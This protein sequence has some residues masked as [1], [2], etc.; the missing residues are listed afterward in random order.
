[1]AR[2]AIAAADVRRPPRRPPG[3]GRVDLDVRIHVGSVRD[4]RGLLRAVS[5]G[6]IEA[7]ECLVVAM[8]PGERA[9]EPREIAP[10]RGSAGDRIRVLDIDLAEEAGKRSDVLAVVAHDV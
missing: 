6:G 3:I 5:Q 7:A 8:L 9:S 10:G 4:P 2:G 1:P